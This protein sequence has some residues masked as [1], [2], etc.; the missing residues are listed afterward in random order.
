MSSVSYGEGNFGVMG[1]LP[2]PSESM[3]MRGW[4]G[5][6]VILNT[7]ETLRGT[8]GLDDRIY[9]SVGTGIHPPSL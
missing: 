8:V 1:T 4:Q 7:D 5:N 6:M 9:R 2:V 3:E